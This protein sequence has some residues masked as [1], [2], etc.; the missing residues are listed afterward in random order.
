ML[1]KKKLNSVL[2]FY[3]GFASHYL[4]FL[5]FLPAS[6]RPKPLKFVLLLFPKIFKPKN[7][8]NNKNEEKNIYTC[9]YT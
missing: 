4:I 3:F 8:N 2:N 6:F 9:I 1:E 7:N 5:L